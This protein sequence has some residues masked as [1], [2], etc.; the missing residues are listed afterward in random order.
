MPVNQ[1]T[2]SSTF[3][4]NKYFVLNVIKGLDY[5]VYSCSNPS[6]ALKMAIY[7]LFRRKRLKIYPE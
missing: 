2:E 1:Q 4:S 5:Q 6:K 7:F 3:G